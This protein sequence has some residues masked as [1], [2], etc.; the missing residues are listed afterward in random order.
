MLA[1]KNVVV[2]PVTQHLFQRQIIGIW[3]PKLEHHVSCMLAQ[4]DFVINRSCHQPRPPLLYTNLSL[5]RNIS[6]LHLDRVVVEASKF[7]WI[8]DT[9]LS[10]TG[11]AEV[12]FGLPGGDTFHEHL[13]NIL[14]GLSSCLR[15]HEEC[16][17][18]HGRAEDTEDDVNL[19]LDVDESGRDEVGQSKVLEW[20]VSRSLRTSKA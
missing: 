11:S 19:P 15:K 6:I 13:L 8:N 17:D 9:L 14:K 12:D 5:S 2:V 4:H 1:Q 7:L 20:S 10:T 18:R 16:V 3:Y